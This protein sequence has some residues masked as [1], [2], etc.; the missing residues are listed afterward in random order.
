LRRS[1]GTP[2]RLSDGFAEVSQ[3]IGRLAKIWHF[4]QL[5]CL[6]LPAGGRNVTQKQHTFNKIFLNFAAWLFLFNN[7]NIWIF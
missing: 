2:L 6:T 5:F 7:Q 1:A 3:G 4:F